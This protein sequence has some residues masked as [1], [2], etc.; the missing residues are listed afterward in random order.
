MNFFD[1]YPAFFSSESSQADSNRLA[2][3]YRVLIE[4]NLDLIKGKKILDIGS[5]DGRWSFAA[6]KN[7]AEMVLG[8]EALQKNLRRAIRNMEKY[9]IPTEKYKFILGSIYPEIKKLK[10]NSI[11][12]IFCF[13]FLYHTYNYIQLFAGIKKLN[14]LYLIIDTQIEKS[15]LPIISL[16][17]EGTRIEG[18]RKIVGTPSRPAL[19]LLLEH[20]GFEYQYYDWKNSKVTN[21]DKTNDYKNGARITLVAKRKEEFS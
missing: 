9:Q 7:G 11:D 15:D 6:I 12:T 16:H 21:W 5:H 10:P 19:N 14:P 8:I 4:E 18:E 20:F 17:L 2:N 3:R 1:N 13:G